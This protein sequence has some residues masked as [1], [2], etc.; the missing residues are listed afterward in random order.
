MG[1]YDPAAGTLRIREAKGGRS[2]HVYLNDEGIA[3]FERLAAGRASG[4]FP[5]HE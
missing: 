5:A 1:D 4:D 2:R 3:L